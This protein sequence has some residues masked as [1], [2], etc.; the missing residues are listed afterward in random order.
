MPYSFPNVSI[1]G[2]SQDSRFLDAGFQYSNVRRVTV[3]GLLLDLQNGQ[4]ISGIWDG[5]S[6]QLN[7]GLVATVFNNTA[8]GLITLNGRGFGSGRIEGF[9]FGAGEDVRTKTYTARLLVYESGN[10]FNFTGTYYTGI[11]TSNWQYLQAFS[12]GYA[13]QRKQNGGYSYSH[14]ASITFNSGVGDLAAIPAAKNLARTLF[15]GAALGQAFYSGYTTKAG[16]RFLN[17][18]YNLIT[19]ACSFRE[20]FDF[21]QD[22][23]NYSATRT[24]AFEMAQNGVISVT[25][26]GAIH[27]ILFPTYLN[28]MAAL[29]AEMGGA[30][31][32]C[33]ALFTTYAPGGS[34]PLITSPVAQGKTLDIFDNNLTY[35][36]A[37][38]N[39]PNNSGSYFWDYTTNVARDDG[40]LRVTENGT[41][42]GRG[43][44]KT[45]AYAGATAGFTNNVQPGIAGRVQSVYNSLYTPS[46]EANFLEQKSES[47]APF[48]STV[49]YNYQF[50][51]EV[52][53]VGANGTKRIRIAQADAP[54]LYHYNKVNVIG[55]GEIAQDDQQS[56]LATRRISMS[57]LGERALPLA[58]YLLD[59]KAQAN[60]CIPTGT[61]VFLNEA[62]YSF[63]PNGSTVNATLGWV[64]DNPAPKSI[65]PQ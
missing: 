56:T 62:S 18:S 42:Q 65:A 15:T 14:D 37:F 21:D 46:V 3:E 50:S 54:N 55:V 13:F 59:A 17:E 39:N 31:P 1:L 58:S 12:E 11:D 36:V 48:R 43:E 40:I 2:L 60:L 6:G 20:T 53:I 5:A 32:R 57:L 4:G 49:G 28:A 44:N 41:L 63:T 45:L 30:Y 25:E 51:N 35:S 52:V 7:Q 34:Y 61:E 26:N 8:I 47:Y 10:L 16:K 29:S 27:G 9:T 22:S 24:N 64:F 19:N 23:G 33:N 38:D